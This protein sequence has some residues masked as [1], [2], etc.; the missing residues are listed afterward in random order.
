[1]ACRSAVAAGDGWAGGM[2][3]SNLS[4]GVIP[5]GGVAAGDGWAGG[6]RYGQDVEIVPYSMAAAAEQLARSEALLR[7]VAAG[8]APA[9]LRWYSYDD[10]AI[11]LG[12][13]QPASTID[14]A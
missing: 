1:M 3:L 5:P 6:M 9:T 11:V 2:R 10:P 4:N 13:G 12:V 7:A 14:E 8:E